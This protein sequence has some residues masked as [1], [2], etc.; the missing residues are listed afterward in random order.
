MSFVE[1]FFEKAEFT[2]KTDL[3]GITS[4]AEF[5]ILVVCVKCRPRISKQVGYNSQL[6]SRKQKL[7]GRL[8]NFANPSKKKEHQEKGWCCAKS[9][10]AINPFLNPG[11]LATLIVPLLLDLFAYSHSR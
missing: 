8:C 11:Y 6:K 2:T 7:T 4:S 3:T 1:G 9:K 10:P 5:K